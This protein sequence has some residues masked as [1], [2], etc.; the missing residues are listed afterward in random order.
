MKT[1][2]PYLVILIIT[3]HSI[4]NLQSQTSTEFWGMTT[5]GGYGFGVVFSTDGNG[6]NLTSEHVIGQ[7][8][9][10]APIYTHLCEALNGKLYGMTSEGVNSGVIY[11][12]D[13]STAVFEIKAAFNG[14]GNGSVP[15]GSLVLASNGLL[16][17][18]T[19]EGGLYNDGVLFE[20]NPTSS[21]LIKKVDFNQLVNG[22]NP[23]GS[24]IQADNG[25]LYGMTKVGG[26]EY[27]GTLFEYDPSVNSLN[28]LYSFLSST[29]DGYAPFGS[30]I[31]N[32]DGKLY[33]MTTYGGANN[34]GVIF[35]FDP[36]SLDYTKLF[37]FDSNNTGANP[38]G[39]LMLADNEHM[40]GLTMSGGANS[41]GT[42]FEF[43]S[44][45]SLFIKRYDFE[46]SISGGLPRGSLM[47]ATNGKLYGM[48]YQGMNGG[49]VFEFDPVNFVYST[50]YTF[51]DNPN[52]RPMGSLMQASNGK[53]Y[54]M[55]HA[56]G[57]CGN[58]DLFEFDLNDFSLLS[59]LDF[60][61]LTE[62][63]FPYGSLVQASNGMLYG[64]TSMGG[65]ND[66]GVL[67]EYDR[68]SSAYK[69][70]SF[71]DVITSGENPTGSL[72][73]ASNGKLYGMTSFGGATNAGVIFEF[74]P[75][76]FTISTIF[77]FGSTPNGYRPNELLIQA[78]N[79]KLYGMTR[80]GGINNT[81][82]LF[83]FD[84]VSNTY[85]ELHDF[86]DASGSSPYG[87][88][89]QASNGK[90][91]GLT[92]TGGSSGFGVLF[93]YDLSTATYTAKY[94]FDGGI[95]GSKPSGSLIQGSNGKLYGLAVGGGQN[96]MGVLFEYNIVNGNMSNKF[97]FDGTDH[98][99]APRGTL[100]L[101]SNGNMYGLTN[102]GGIND[103]GVLFEFNPSTG[104][105]T[106]K[107]DFTGANG[108]SPR[109][110]NL[111]E[112]NK[113]IGIEE[114]AANGFDISVYPN[115]A[116][117]LIYIELPIMSDYHVSIY[118]LLGESVQTS[119][120]MQTKT[121]RLNVADLALGMYL[122]KIGND[123]TS[124]VKRIIIE[125]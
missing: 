125:R 38:E 62:G 76:A 43:D 8:P 94:N 80:Y 20:F 56:G 79:G 16:Y 88:V 27:T 37:D 63:G 85:N 111:I 24:L 119:K 5:N 105:C 60:S 10:G 116:S 23:M 75:V 51:Y 124:V 28:I 58:G 81:G 25:K 109:Y 100:L 21:A 64:L 41:Y 40:Y 104:L 14:S 69:I 70:I 78:T 35:S 91:Y 74:D 123:Q 121:I 36:D 110:T 54:G 57:C 117:D 55:T 39:S 73:E 45:N 84:P 65:A 68:D 99:R 2:I 22:G 120:S 29:P 113:T 47:Q 106:K 98:G 46:V 9:F 72:I 67:F 93:E 4:N 53:L 103:L 31:Q 122:V 26:N 97:S 44:D 112:I 107:A 34:Y 96:N 15:T 89:I 6:D 95:C 18:M 115:P 12:Y 30:L 101:A 49:G 52:S 114:T 71:G 92:E 1:I 13:P 66:A 19:S 11:E 108:A 87:S 118:T 50:R 3:G 32:T 102:A 77:S 83:E 17:G 59:L 42:L 86:A 33:G 48:T 90:L 7:Q 61:G 82:V